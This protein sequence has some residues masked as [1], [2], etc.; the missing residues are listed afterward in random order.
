[1]A[2]DMGDKSEAPTS[3]KLQ[4]ARERGQVP[5]SQD[6]VAVIIM[7]G[8]VATAALLGPG[9][10]N[11]T[12]GAMR[13]ALSPD[14][15]TNLT[16]RN[17]PGS[18][19][20]LLATEVG[21]AVLPF[22]VIMVIVAALAHLVQ[23]GP[24]YASK[25]L[26]LDLNRINPINGFKKL[27]GKRTLVKT[28]LDLCKLAAVVM[29]LTITVR[30]EMPAILAL[31]ELSIRQGVEVACAIVLRVSVTVLS[32]LLVL[33]LIDML[34][35]RFQFTQDNKMTK[36]QVKD[37]RK[38]TDGDPQIKARQM[39]IARQIAMQRLGRDVPTADVIVTNPTHFSVALRY[40]PE[41][42]GA[43][44]VV[45]K[46]ADYMAL[47]I[48]Y[49]ATAHDVPI[50]ERPPL[51]RALYREVEPGQQ[52]PHHHFEAVAEVLAYVYRL[53]GRAPGVRQPAATAS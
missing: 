20:A 5:K 35:Q 32:V 9:L 13:F 28:V 41:T 25:A 2:D 7:S 50:V 23:T 21:K 18:L 51:A 14:S 27:F 26:E 47:K 31:L 43:P 37:E 24:M 40:D 11:L 34:Y 48:R 36:Q 4:D 46:G 53:E 39:R 17:H 1:M 6:L 38:D 42:M 49:I 22:F 3:K 44:V 52:I 15:L 30:G 33:A 29:A 45:A 12:A 16:D 8:A 10:F 19:T